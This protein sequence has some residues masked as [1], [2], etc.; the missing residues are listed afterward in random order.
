MTNIYKKVFQFSLSSYID[1][2]GV[3]NT[4]KSINNILLDWHFLQEKF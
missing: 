3:K 2:V 1:I 4:Y